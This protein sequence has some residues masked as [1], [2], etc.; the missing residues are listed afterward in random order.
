MERFGASRFSSVARALADEAR[1]C[2]LAAPGFRSPP[3]LPGALR[4][5]R[6]AGDR[7]VVAIRLT[8][9]PPAEVITD[10]VEGVVVAN[11]LAGDRAALARHA[12]LEA[13]DVA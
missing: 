3:R 9:R 2:G 1:R 8:G 10:M 4:T 12:L 7:S 13:L 5:I 6:R 11:R